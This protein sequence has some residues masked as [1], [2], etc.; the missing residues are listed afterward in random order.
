MFYQ[1]HL[2]HEKPLWII[3]V[4]CTDSQNP[5]KCNYFFQESIEY[6]Y[7]FQESIK[8]S[9]IKSIKMGNPLFRKTT[10]FM[11]SGRTCNVKQPAFNLYVKSKINLELFLRVIKTYAINNSY[12]QCSYMNMKNYKNNEHEK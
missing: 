10:K 9:K 6:N 8:Q 12:K 11:I 3:S 5:F 7:F 2:A 4:A 1:Q